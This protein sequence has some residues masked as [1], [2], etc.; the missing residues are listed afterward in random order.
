MLAMALQNTGDLLTARAEY[1]QARFEAEDA[2]RTDEQYQSTLIAIRKG[3]ADLEGVLGRLSVKL[4]H[5]PP[6]TDVTVDG[7][8]VPVAKLAEPL[9]VA[10]GSVTVEATAP[11]GTVARR[12]VAVNAGQSAA[13]ELPFARHEP[14]PAPRGPGRARPRAPLLVRPSRRGA[15][16]A[17]APALDG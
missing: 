11:D 6:G 10:A 4:V 15:A 16:P 5:A 8:R 9:F 14:R 3:L 17:P 2:V 7:E 13:V 12:V 1:E